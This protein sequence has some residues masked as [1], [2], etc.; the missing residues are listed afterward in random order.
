M[1]GI[2]RTCEHRFRTLAIISISLHWACNIDDPLSNGDGPLLPPRGGGPPGIFLKKVDTGLKG[3][4]WKVT[5][6]EGPENLLRLS[7]AA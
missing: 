5:E 1:Q 6:N 3:L 4:K 2:H 7:V